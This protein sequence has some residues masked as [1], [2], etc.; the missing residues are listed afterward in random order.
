MSE[1]KLLPCPWCGGEGIVEKSR[2][3]FFPKCSNE[4][5]LANNM[6]TDGE[7]GFVNVDFQTNDMAIEAWNTRVLA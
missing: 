5:C 4:N 7:S 3:R 2:H 1:N 6:E